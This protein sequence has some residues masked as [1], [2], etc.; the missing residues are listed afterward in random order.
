MESTKSTVSTFPEIAANGVL[1]LLAVACSL[2][3]GKSAARK[4]PSC[5]KAVSQSA[6]TRYGAKGEAVASA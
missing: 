5:K 1:A 3:A 6:S 2:L 4:R